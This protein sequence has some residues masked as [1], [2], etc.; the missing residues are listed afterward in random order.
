MVKQT[1]TESM[2]MFLK[3]LIDNEDRCWDFPLNDGERYCHFLVDSCPYGHWEPEA[4][5]VDYIPSRQ[6]FHRCY[7]CRP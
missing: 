6:E 1:T 3:A 7:R 2:K 5:F 4:T